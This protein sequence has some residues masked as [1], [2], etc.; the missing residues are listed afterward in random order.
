MFFAENFGNAVLRRIGAV[1]PSF[2]PRIR[3]DFRHVTAVLEKRPNRH[4]LLLV[5]T[6]GKPN[7]IDHYEGR[8]GIEDTAKAI[9]EARAKGLAVFGVTIDKKAQAYF[10]RLFGRGSYAIVHHLA[11]L[12]A[13]LPRIYRHLAG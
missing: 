4:R 6:D 5:I 12:T 1:K 8:Y 2:Y 3:A 9:A 11:Q 7:D 13:A 10:P